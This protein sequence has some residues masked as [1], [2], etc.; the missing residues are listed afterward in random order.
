M[1]SSERTG[2]ATAP[3][4]SADLSGRD[5]ARSLAGLIDVLDRADG[6][7]AARPRRS[8]AHRSGGV[9]TVP[10]RSVQRAPVAR[11]APA[12]AL[13][14]EPLAPAHVPAAPSRLRALTRRVALW[15][16]G[17]QGEYLAWRCA[18]PST[19]AEP[20]ATPRAGRLRTLVRRMALWGSGP[21]GEYLAWG[22]PARN[23]AP[24]PSADRPV[25]LHEMPSTPMIQPAAPSPAAALVPRGPAF[26]AAARVIPPVPTEGSGASSPPGSPSRAGRSPHGTGWPQ[27][28]TGSSFRPAALSTPISASHRAAGPARARGDPTSCPVRGSPPPR[29]APFAPG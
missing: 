26:P 12:P 15:G 20:G 21:E 28:R 7:R 19:V 11:P 23:A 5:A 13:V 8:A 3:R 6:A 4:T 9:R 2:S 17:P 10:L 1:S 14:A 27:Q 29:W 24:R 16:A 25:V 22:G 18:A